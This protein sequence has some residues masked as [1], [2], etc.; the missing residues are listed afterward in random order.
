[1]AGDEK[2][3]VVDTV[4]VFK[5]VADNFLTRS[6][7][8]RLSGFC[9]KDESNRLEVA[10]ELYI[11]LRKHACLKCRLAK[12]LLAPIVNVGAKA[13]G[14]SQEKLKSKFS[15]PYWRRGLVNVIK[16]I[17]WFGVTKPYTPGAPFQIVWNITRACNLR[18]IHCYERSEPG[19]PVKG[20][21]TTEEAMRGI[22]VLSKAGVV[23]IAFSGG[24]PTIRPDML[25][26]VKHAAKRGIYVAMATNAIA[27]ASR[28]KVKEYKQAGL[29]FVQISLDGVNP[30]THDSFRGVPGAFEKTVQGIKNCVAEELFV[31][32]AATAT[33]YNYEEIPELVGFADKLGADWFMLYN[34]VPTGRGR[35]IAKADLTP[36]EREALLITCWNMLKSRRINVLSTAPY[37][38]RIAQETEEGK[39]WKRINSDPELGRIMKVEPLEAGEAVPRQLSYEMIIPTHFYNP[40]FTGQLI[41]LA[42]FIGGCGA[43]RFYISIEPNG[44]I[45]PCVFFPHDEDVRIGN[46]LK[47]DFEELWKKHQLLKMLRNKD[48]LTENCGSCEYKYTCGGCRARAYGYFRDILAPD[49]GCILNKEY[50]LKI[51]GET[52]PQDN[53]KPQAYI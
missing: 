13:F 37:F 46:I 21:L 2:A 32:V 22:D 31:E 8:T 10:L 20:E 12:R 6:L 28:E 40:K 29:Q 50:W 53:D 17:A 47:D 30:E 52:K 42:D 14:V 43:G 26:L 19:I 3:S 25:H 49:P 5:K 4:Q 48:I 36:E 33:R 16:G 34:F 9:E 15:D 7:L 41:R 11:G 1:M 38:A 18:C 44:D 35:D 39:I 45:Y 24:E 27:F 51:R 23:I